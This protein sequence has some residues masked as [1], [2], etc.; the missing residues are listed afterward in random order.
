MNEN[1][2]QTPMDDRKPQ[3]LTAVLSHCGT[4]A[5]FESSVIILNFSYYLLS[6]VL[7]RHND[8]KATIRCRK[9]YE[10]KEYPF[11]NRNS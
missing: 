11:K 6:L 4:W 7:N 9:C 1:G 2:L 5:F 3:P 8:D 10:P